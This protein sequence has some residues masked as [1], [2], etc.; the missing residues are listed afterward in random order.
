MKIFTNITK[1]TSRDNE[2]IKLARKTRDGHSGNEQIFIEGLR[3]A[4]EALRAELKIS[5]IFF[6]E[7][8]AKN[9][10]HRDFLKNAARFNLLEVSDK[11]FDSIADTKTSQG[12]IVIAEKPAHGKLIIEKR[13][14]NIEF[15]LVVLLHQINNPAN[16]GA[17]MRTAEAV[18]ATG[19]ITTKNS[20][21]VF[22]PKALR[23]SMGA[24]LR[25]PI[26]TNADYTEV[27][28]WSRERKLKSVCAD[29]KSRKNY[30]EIDW[31]SGRLLIVGSEGHGLTK[32]YTVF[33]KVI[34]GLNNA[35]TIAGAP[36]DR[37]RPLEPIK[38]N[39]ITI[40]SRQ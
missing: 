8:F 18:G 38:I 31:T 17:I 9:E 35:R 6:N 13:L 36:R 7:N 12:V 11:V 15:P 2:R 34:D 20:A 5:D 32:K 40:Q 27:L 39:S 24:S 10:R 4:E 37:E 26:W 28:S 19:V 1:I 33:G 21:D 23:G 3:L 29:I 22:S 30:T 25:L 14:S 16:L